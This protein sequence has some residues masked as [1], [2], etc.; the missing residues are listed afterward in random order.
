MIAPGDKVEL[1]GLSPGDHRF[2]CCIHS[3]MHAL[4]KVEASS[5]DGRASVA[6]LGAKV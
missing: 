4:I 6:V 5:G 1:R 3:W 2:Q